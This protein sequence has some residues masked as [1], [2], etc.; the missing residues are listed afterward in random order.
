V[1]DGVETAEPAP[2]ERVAG[3]DGVDGQPDAPAELDAQ[4]VVDGGHVDTRRKVGA[5][6]GA[7]D[8]QFGPDAGAARIERQPPVVVGL[9]VRD[10]DGPPAV[11]VEDGLHVVLAVVVA[12]IRLDGRPA[13]PEQRPQIVERRFRDHAVGERR[14]RV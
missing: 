9:M 4:D 10:A 2:H 14:R 12:R 7:V 8:I 11:S 13:L 1:A 6:G 3:G 5:L